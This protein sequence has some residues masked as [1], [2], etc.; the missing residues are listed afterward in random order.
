MRRA[1][2]VAVT[3]VCLYLVAVSATVASRNDRVRPLYDGFVPPTSYHFVEPPG[4]FA[5]GNVKPE[6]MSTTIELGSAGS[7]AAGIATPDGQF[8]VNLARGAIAAT[9]GDT[10]V[11]V[12][13]TPLAPSQLP[14]VP[15]GLRPNGNAYRVE[16]TYRPSGETVR[17]FAKPGTML[18]EIP[19]LGDHLFLSSDADTWAAIASQA[20]PPRELSL[21]ATFGAPGTYLAATNLPE[22][23]T[24]TSHSDGAVALGIGVATLALVIFGAALFMVRRRGRPRAAPPEE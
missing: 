19:E 16:M 11:D 5:S 20:I 21:T 18:I 6:A 12:R 23:T 4:F 14:A 3:V 9:N 13:I 8:V 15:G 2:L 24:S 7:E 17:A 22:L 10:T 1:S